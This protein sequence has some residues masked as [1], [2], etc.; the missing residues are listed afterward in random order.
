[1]NV[2]PQKFGIISCCGSECAGGYITRIAAGKVIYELRSA[3]VETISLPRL[4]FGTTTDKH[5]TR[6]H[7]TITIDGC[8]KACAQKA[9]EKYSGKAIVNI[10]VADIID[11][12]AEN[13]NLLSIDEFLI[14]YKAEI[15]KITGIITYTLD[16][17]LNM[18]TKSSTR[19]MSGCGTTCDC[20]CGSGHS[21][22]GCSHEGDA[23]KNDTVC[24]L[25]VSTAA[26]SKELVIYTKTSCPFCAKTILEYREK[27]IAFCEI[28]ISLDSNAKQLCSETYG[29]DR[30]PIIVKDG[31][32]VQI[33]DS[34]GK[35]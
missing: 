32:V 25:K 14:Q 1:M 33:G 34:E 35:G 9:V 22:C 2:Q 28:N 3:Q 10:N 18:A 23:H 15:R 31:V 6:L 19:G 26:D 11:S 29:V 20:G 7:P 17:L 13:I 30:V 16:T 21:A 24:P 4:L 12:T 5:F 27:G 8:S